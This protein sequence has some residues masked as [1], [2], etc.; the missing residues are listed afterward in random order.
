MNVIYIWFVWYIFLFIMDYLYFISGFCLGVFSFVIFLVYSNSNSKPKFLKSR[1]FRQSNLFALKEIFRQFHRISKRK[2]EIKN[3]Y[4]YLRNAVGICLDNNISPKNSSE[5]LLKYSNLRESLFLADITFY[6]GYG[7]RILLSYLKH[8]DSCHYCTFTKV[9]AKVI[10]CSWKKDGK[11]FKFI[12][13][14]N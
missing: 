11:H 3:V 4:F 5:N 12:G 13:C 1:L 2:I 14:Q 10:L 8:A 9:K 7:S 6:K